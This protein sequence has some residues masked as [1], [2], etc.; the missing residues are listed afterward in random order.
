M[1]KTSNVRTFSRSPHIR[2]S[3]GSIRKGSI[4]SVFTE[5]EYARFSDKNSWENDLFEPS[6]WLSETEVG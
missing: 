6:A 3:F 5:S 2:F 4:S 1:L